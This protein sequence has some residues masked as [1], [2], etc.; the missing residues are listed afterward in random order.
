MNISTLACCHKY[1]ALIRVARL[2]ANHHIIFPASQSEVS[3]I[4]EE[5]NPSE[6]S[7][8]EFENL[9]NYAWTPAPDKTHPFLHINL[10]VPTKIRFRKSL[11]EILELTN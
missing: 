4:M 5:H 3:R 1:H 2:N 9:I 7:K 8:S 6:L 10:K 11:D